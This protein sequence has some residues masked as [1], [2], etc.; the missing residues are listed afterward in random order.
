MQQGPQIFQTASAIRWRSFK[1]TMRVLL[2]V[3]IF[4][5]VVL[6][7]AVISATMPTVPNLEAR[8]EAYKPKLDA[9]NPFTF[10]Q[11]FNKKYKGFKEFL[12]KKQ[13]D[14]FLKNSKQP[15]RPV[16]HVAKIRAVF[17]TP[18]T[19][20]TSLPDLEKYGDSLNVIFPEWLFIDTLTHTLQTKIDSAGFA[21]M[22]KKNLR[23]MPMLTNYNSFK[24]PK[25][26]FDGALLHDILN[27]P[28]KRKSFINM[29][30]DTLSYYKL[31][32]INIDFEELQEKTSG[33]LTSFQK[34]LYESLHAK[35][36]TVTMDVAVHNNDYDYEK[37]SDYNDYIILMAYDQFNDA[38]GA[39]PVSSQKWIE[40][41]VDWTAKKIDPD[42]IILGIAGY[43]YDWVTDEEGKTSVRNITYDDAINLAKI[44]NAVVDFDNDTYNLHFQYS[45]LET[46]NDSTDELETKR[47]VVWFTD[48]AT[49]FNVLRFSDE[50]ATAGSA[51]WRL[52][53]EDERMWN[54]YN[55]DLSNEALAIKPFDFTG[56]L[57]IS[58]TL[59]D[60]TY[61][62]TFGN[63]GE[64]LDIIGTPQPGKIKLELDSS[65]LLIAEQHYEQLP[66]GYIIQKFAEDPT[67]SGPGH[68][69]IL[70]F[71]DGPDP[72]WTPQILNILEKEKVPASF[73]VV[74]LQVE[75]NIPLLQRINKL[76][77]EIGNH[78]FTHSNVA[79]MS[80]QRA[81]LEMKLTRLLI[82]SI[83]GR[84][85]ILFRAPYNA[86][87]EP[88][89]FEELEPIARSRQENYLTVGES[90]DPN[91]WQLGVTADSIV[92][93]TIYQVESRGASIILLHDAGGKTRQAT[94]DALPRIIE[95]FK[96]KGYKFTT[97][98]DLMG[99]TKDDVMP[100]VPA[101]K[102]NWITKVNFFFAEVYYWA[103]HILFALFIVGIVFSVGRIVLMAALAS[104]QKKKEAKTALANALLVP[105]ANKP[106]VSIIVPAYNE[107]INAA[108]T[109]RSLLMQDY[110]NLQVVFV[111]DGSKDN[112]YN[113]V[114]E[115]FADV[116]NVFV[117]T[118]PNGGK[119]SALNFGIA[120]ADSEY[121][122]CIDADT[123]LKA[124]AVSELMKKFYTPDGDVG[125]V[126]GNVKGWQRSKHDYKM[127]E[128]RIYYFAKF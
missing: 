50:Y 51:L 38:S 29:L 32:G 30:T 17:Y 42:K 87:S 27:N 84:S 21:M 69:L 57:N 103:S 99:K 100:K 96:T 107:E 28:D 26:D 43:G 53:S 120:K 46:K 108:R 127:A 90:I 79:K 59:N 82:E 22:R 54:F 8:S 80:P 13:K 66:S 125:A 58:V 62:Q 4:L 97:V 7:V 48:A 1:W 5:I 6:T 40:E 104:L 3:A 88:H 118:K 16:E 12:I 116:E 25:A 72:E 73:F 33:P 35:Q 55:R 93:R 64:I 91:D 31:D 67:P 119:A 39:G 11:S 74:G 106:L 92:A 45:G 76:G 113:N 105:V 124:D 122:V 114:S 89:T 117:Y 109:V 110:P 44:K 95:Y 83:T 71:D 61:D 86:D 49:T 77:F 81:A 20:K 23:I 115:A 98:A 70:T 78:T 56:M 10:A 85:T 123:Q 18:W 101:T 60:V 19:S 2:L 128:H 102:D 68:K 63:G 47:H 14:D 36:M 75:N 65:E 9:S 112:T 111:D 121:V 24:R 37:L 41:A 52:G 126:A 34:E 15:A 94:V